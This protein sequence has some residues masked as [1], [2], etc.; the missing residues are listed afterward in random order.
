MVVN[1]G[2]RLTICEV[3]R[4]MRRDLSAEGKDDPETINLLNMAYLSG[5]AMSKKLRKYKRGW[6]RG[7]WK[8][9]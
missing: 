1:M 9:I 7:W 8:K 4:Q 3:H 6:D 5:K 2:K